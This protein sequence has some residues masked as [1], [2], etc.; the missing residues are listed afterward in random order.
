MN[1]KQAKEALEEIDDCARMD[2]GVNPIG[3]YSVLKQFID[4]VEAL[5]KHNSI[6][7]VPA[8]LRK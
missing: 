6:K 1:I 4:E 2:V 5:L 7:Q 8:L 3:P